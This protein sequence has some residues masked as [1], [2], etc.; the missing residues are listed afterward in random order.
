MTSSA[1]ANNNKQP[2]EEPHDAQIFVSQMSDLASLLP[3][4][5]PLGK[6]SKSTI[7]NTSIAHVNASHRHRA[8]ATQQL[9]LLTDEC[10]SLRRE[11]NEWR[12]RAGGG[13][14]PPIPVPARGEMF[15]VLLSGDDT[16]FQELEEAGMVEDDGEHSGT[17]ASGDREQAYSHSP[18]EIARPRSL[19]ERQQQH[20]HPHHSAVYPYPPP[21]H[22]NRHPQ[23]AYEY[24][25][26][27]GHHHYAGAMG[28]PHSAPPVDMSMHMHHPQPRAGYRRIPPADPEPGH[29]VGIAISQSQRASTFG[30]HTPIAMPQQQQQHHQHRRMS[31]P[32][33][34][35][36]SIV[37]PNVAGP[38]SASA[39]EGGA[40]LR[41][42]SSARARR[43]MTVSSGSGGT[44]RMRSNTPR[45]WTCLAPVRVW[46]RTLRRGTS[47]R[48]RRI[49]D[50]GRGMSRNA[51]VLQ[52]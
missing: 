2:K 5:A 7:V 15:D 10:D 41:P 17:S 34:P 36:L 26:P 20:P 18:E 24:D 35:S 44:R 33:L 32:L 30:M 3:S 40:Y 25:Y 48:G 6:P 19:D 4:L 12:E 21:A 38:A 52:L 42:R 8:L 49:H 22:Y 9:R 37:I 23:S 43:C 27:N 51:Y 45:P 47:R 13:G 1:K 28:G 39:H 31:Q 29:D 46:S 50:S 16:Y 11:V 14:I